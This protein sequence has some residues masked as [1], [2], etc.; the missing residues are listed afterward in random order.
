MRMKCIG[1]Q[2]VPSQPPPGLH[3]GVLALCRRCT[4]SGEHR[5]YI[6]APSTHP[7]AKGATQLCLF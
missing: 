2:S 3:K 5:T 4:A 6:K 7:Q 1:A